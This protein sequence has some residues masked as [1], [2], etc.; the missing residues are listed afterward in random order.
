M[1]RLTPVGLFVPFEEERGDALVLLRRIGLGEDEREVRDRAVADPRLPPAQHPGIAV[2]P[3]GGA[4]LG[5]VAPDLGLGEAE[6]A[7]EIAFAE[8][9][10]VAA[11][12]LL[13]AELQ[14]RELDERDL[15][16]ERGAD[17]RVDAA[18]LLGDE[19]VRDV[20]HPHPAVLLRDRPAK[21]PERGHLLQHLGRELLGA[22]ALAGARRDLPVG[23]ILGEL[24]YLLLLAG[25]VEVHRRESIEA[26]ARSVSGACL[27][28]RPSQ[29]RHRASGAA[30]T[31][32]ERS[33]K[34][35][36]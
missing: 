28:I 4:D 31:P 21:E 8:A 15:H 16:R 27:P 14:E 33:V 22:I 32:P 1:D 9:W 20:V 25:E 11:L 34:G 26:S 24:A 6:A 23:A 35:I 36:R 5:R 12:L 10:E 30:E 13:G 19:R 18:D 3:R 2:A 29:P 17:R 7:D